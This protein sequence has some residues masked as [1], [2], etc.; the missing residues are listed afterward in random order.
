ML[1]VLLP[2]LREMVRTARWG[3]ALDLC[4]TV[5]LGLL[6]AAGVIMLLPLLT[7]AGV[8]GNQTL[9]FGSA[10]EQ[11]LN[12]SGLSLPLVLALYIAINIGQA[13][14]QHWQT[15]LNSTICEGFEAAQVTKFYRAVTYARWS[16]FLSVKRDELFHVISTELSQVV[17]GVLQLQQ[18]F[19]AG[20]ISLIQIVIAFLLEPHLTL[21]VLTCGI[22]FTGAMQFS[23]RRAQLVG[24]VM[25]ASARALFSETSEHFSGMKEV[26]SYGIEETQ[27]H[28]FKKH[29]FKVSS[30]Y[31]QLKGLKSQ[32][33]LMYKVGLALVISLFYYV[34]I[35]GF[36]TDPR[37]LIVIYLIFSR[38]WP[39]F[40]IFQTG[41]QSLA[42]MM[43]AAQHVNEVMSR[44]M[45]AEEHISSQQKAVRMDLKSELL[46]TN[47]SFRYDEGN[48]GY[49]VKDANL[50]LPAGTTAAVVGPSGSGKSTLADLVL[51]LITPETGDV[52][53][54][55]VRLS[56]ENR[57]RWR[58]S[59]GYVPQDAFLFH[60]SIRD[61]L[62][63][64][65]P[66]ATEDEIWQALKMAAIDKFV[67]GLP[68]KLDTLVGDRGIRLS[69][70][71]RQ[72]IVLARALL[73]KPALLIMDEATSSLDGENEKR[74]QAAVESLR[75]KLTILIIA[76]RIS[77]IRNT[78]QILVMEQ[79]EIVERG[80]YDALT[81]NAAS[82]FCRLTGL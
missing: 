21:M 82:H 11:Y 55:D 51:G 24:E 68:E 73:R 52:W 5:L 46:L 4:L 64:S 62:L 54:D 18:M 40:T 81:A 6:E 8:S 74:I 30:I 12:F 34:A 1:K 42:V 79:G 15:V 28:T 39:R 61:N 58:Q 57:H 27:V 38:L 10:L 43:P 41:I 2:Y 14:M 80:T 56:D 32:T 59:I 77:T 9:G 19:A 29:W 76:H 35:E 70:G 13:L 20:I 72:R 63:W 45:E 67:K 47:V 44:C 49:A 17:N 26:K 25:S 71:E 65:S 75:G 50:R 78:D 31:I 60:S 37:E 3:I 69:G 53:I 23:R 36:H 7:L 66:Q 16:Y 33:T 22:L 48:K